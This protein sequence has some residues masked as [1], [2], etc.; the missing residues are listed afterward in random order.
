[1]YC[2]YK[3]NINGIDNKVKAR[4]HAKSAIEAPVPFHISMVAMSSIFQG[5]YIRRNG[6][7]LQNERNEIQG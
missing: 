5:R 7:F 3:I 4:W 2:R 1:V 6:F